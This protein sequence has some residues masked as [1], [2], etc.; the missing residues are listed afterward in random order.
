[1]LIPMTGFLLLRRLFST[2]PSKVILCGILI[3]LPDKV[4]SGQE[5]VSDGK[6]GPEHVEQ[7][8]DA[9][10]ATSAAANSADDSIVSEDANMKSTPLRETEVVIA[11]AEIAKAEVAEVEV[12][13]AEVTEEV[14]EQK[15]SQKK[16]VVQEKPTVVGSANAEDLKVGDAPKIGVSKVVEIDPI[17][18][19]AGPSDELSDVIDVLHE[20]ANSADDKSE[21]ASETSQPETFLKFKYSDSVDLSNALDPKEEVASPSDRSAQQRVEDQA[22]M[23]LELRRQRAAKLARL[24]A[25]R[26]QQQLRSGYS[27][28]RPS[29]NAIPMMKSRYS[30]PVIYVPV[31]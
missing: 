17:L 1:M 25:M 20:S 31:Y 28:L 21:V 3:S 29:W 4:S 16:E 23:L 11:E 8:K 6:K 10:S 19:S 24:R 12:A 15:E 7:I 2:V 30:R 22:E 26:L 5:L 9:S 13:K 14:T 27:P 18:E